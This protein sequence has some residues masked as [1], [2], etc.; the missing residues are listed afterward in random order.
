MIIKRR[1][2]N[3]KIS[4]A[5]IGQNRSSDAI[6]SLLTGRLSVHQC[7][8]LAIFGEKIASFLTIPV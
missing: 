6:V 8:F 4:R 5:P 3:A 1:K 7:P 2:Y